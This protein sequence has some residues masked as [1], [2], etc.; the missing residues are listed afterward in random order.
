MK[1]RM[2]LKEGDTFNFLTVIA[3]HHT[4]NHYR[5]YYIFK[6]TCGNEIILLG[7]NV[8]SGNTKSCGCFQHRYMKEHNLLPNNLGVKRMIIKQY[9]RHAKDRNIKYDLSEEKFIELIE[10]PCHYCGATKTNIIKTKNCKQGYPYTGIDRIDSVK[11]YTDENCVPCCGQCN[12][13]KMAMKRE[14]FLTWIKSVY[15]YSCQSL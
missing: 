13:A 8:V 4:G 14:E 10:Q 15:V 9:T 7:S 12:K 3:Y 11:G 6:C 2:N 5:K 1:K